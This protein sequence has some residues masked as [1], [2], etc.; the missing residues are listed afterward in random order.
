MTSS[1][2]VIEDSSS[3]FPILGSRFF[4]AINP[5]SYSYLL[6]LNCTSILVVDLIPIEY[7]S[8]NP[9]SSSSYPSLSSYSTIFFYCFSC[10][11]S[12]FIL[13]YCTTS[14]FFK[15]NS[16]TKSGFCTLRAGPL[17]KPT[18]L[19]VVFKLLS[20]IPSSYNNYT[21]LFTTML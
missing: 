9:L 10:S 15:S 19:S 18:Q 21:V 20:S 2:I 1:P 13:C 12:I 16:G 5:S 6:F 11:I 17:H 7:S 3:R 4:G 14:T 8:A